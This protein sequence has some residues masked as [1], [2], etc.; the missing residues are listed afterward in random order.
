MKRKPTKNRAQTRQTNKT[1]HTKN[2]QNTNN[3]K[4]TKHIS[5]TIRGL[6]L[7]QLDIPTSDT[8]R[9]IIIAIKEPALPTNK[10]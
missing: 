10:H 4:Q 5:N 8:I 1:N 9:H 3:K 2:K 7:L 6:I